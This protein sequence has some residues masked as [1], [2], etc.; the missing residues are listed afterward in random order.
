[1][2][3]D[4]TPEMYA[5]I[6]ALFQ[7]KYNKAE[8]QGSPI[9]KI[10]R[11]LEAGTATFRDADLYA[12]EVSRML[13]ESLIEVLQLDA[14]PNNQLYYNIAQR[15][16]GTSLQETYGLVSSVA[17]EVQEALNHANDV[18]LKAVKAEANPE[19][20]NGLLDKAVEAQD[21]T[22]LNQVLQSPVENLLM[23]AVDDTVKANASLQ[24]RAGLQ[25][26]IKRTTVGKCCDWCQALAGTYEYPNHVPKDIY[27]RHQ[28]CRCSVEYV[29]AEKKQNVWTKKDDVLTSSEAKALETELINRLRQ[30]TT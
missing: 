27:R 6:M 10:R 20:I 17:Q 25:P 19:R 24:S 9:S 15:T 23:S 22:T 5:R 14:L 29:G 4:I 8:V 28:N 11:K 18:A 30:I 1:M 2:A 7:E 26:I 12:T 3:T 21:Q 13:S 16:I